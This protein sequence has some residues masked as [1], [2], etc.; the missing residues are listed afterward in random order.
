MVLFNDSQLDSLSSLI[1][2]L[3]L[4][5]RA[6]LIK[7][8]GTNIIS[9]L[10]V[11]PLPNNAIYKQVVQDDSIF[12]IGRQGTGKSTVFAVAQERFRH[13]NREVSAYI[14]VKTLYG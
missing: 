4:A 1:N 13:Q 11:D 9:H 10:Y 6:E 14:D 12:L 8:G 2:S 7:E 3:R 5:Q